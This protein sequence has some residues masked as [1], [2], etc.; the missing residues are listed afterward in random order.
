MFNL[1][2]VFLTEGEDRNGMMNDLAMF[3]NEIGAL[4]KEEQAERIRQKYGDNPE[5]Q[6][7]VK[8]VLENKDEDKDDLIGVYNKWKNEVRSF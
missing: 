2:I 7:M 6:E 8:K 4:P 5:V 3:W 1:W